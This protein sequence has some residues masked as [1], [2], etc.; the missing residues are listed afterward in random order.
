M[1]EAGTKR[2]ALRELAHS[3]AGDKGDDVNLGLVAYLPEFYPVLLREATPERVKSYFGTLVKGEV[4]RYELPKIHALNFVL[5]NAL[6]GGSSKSLRQDLH[7]KA[8][9]GPFLDMEIDIPA[10]LPEADFPY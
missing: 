5:T 10:D 7:G 3:R 9:S 8:L 1:P 2:V 6:E 4:R